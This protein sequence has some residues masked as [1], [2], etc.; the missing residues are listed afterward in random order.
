MS[1]NS[2]IFYTFHNTIS[3]GLLQTWRGSTQDKHNT[4]YWPRRS[5]ITRYYGNKREYWPRR[6]NKT[7]YYGNKREYW[8]RQQHNTLPWEQA[9]ILTKREQH[10]MLLWEQTWILTKTVHSPSLQ[11]W[12]CD[13]TSQN[14]LFNDLWYQRLRVQLWSAQNN[15]VWKLLTVCAFILSAKFP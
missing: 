5:N 4:E 10:S 1:F 8:P 11:K 9:W 2:I 3:H 14:K 12:E 7:R 15:R 6:S 13:F